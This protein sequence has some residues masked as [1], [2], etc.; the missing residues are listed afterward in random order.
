MKETD[1]I[2]QG[3]TGLGQIIDCAVARYPD[4]LAI[5]SEDTRLTYRDFEEQVS[6]FALVLQRDGVKPGDPVAIISRNCAE[7]LVAEFA[8]LRLGAVVVKINWRFAPDELQYLLDF[9]HVHHAI[10]RYERRDWGLQVYEHTR[11]H[12][13]F[14]LLNPDES[15]TSPFWAQIQSISPTE[16]FIPRQMDA[17]APALR[18]HTSGTTGRPKCVLHTHGAMLRQLRNCLS[19]L[20][21][22]P[23][24]VFQTTSQLF[25]IA[26]VGAYMV[27]AVGGTLVL[28]S[29][30]EPEEYLAS[31][32]REEVDGISVIPVI[33]K[34]LLERP[35]L[36]EHTLSRLKFLNYSTT[37]F[38]V[39]FSH[40]TT[41]TVL[42]YNL[43]PIFKKNE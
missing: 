25:H 38:N 27:L 35:D 18:V 1:E 23:G 24:V 30:F 39:V 13:K 29:R 9:N 10:V 21:F 7:F 42:C 2:F 36:G 5:V 37:F 3:C 4:R 8:I 22:E 41:W 20:A 11:D 17:D 12:I 34:R 43:L 6:R 40:L 19:V 14:Y 31:F 15:G 16:Q 33:L 28:M 26:C 32:D